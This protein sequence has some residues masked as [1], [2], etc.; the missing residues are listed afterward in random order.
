MTGTG[1]LVRVEVPFAV[2]GVITNDRGIVEVAAPI[3]HWSIGLHVSKVFSWAKRKGGHA[4]V[5]P[6]SCPAPGPR[7]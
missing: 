4:A 6:S 7:L 3:L 1:T 2:A 5:L